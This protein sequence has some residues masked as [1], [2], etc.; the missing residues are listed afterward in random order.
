MSISDARAKAKEAQTVYNKNKTI[1]YQTKAID[2][3]N[4]WARAVLKDKNASPDQIGECINSMRVICSGNNSSSV[5]FLIDS[6]P[7]ITDID[8]MPAADLLSELQKRYNAASKE[9]ASLYYTGGSTY[10]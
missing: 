5:R 7:S 3:Y 2:A 1:G 6:N 10:V 8:K 4:N 9:I